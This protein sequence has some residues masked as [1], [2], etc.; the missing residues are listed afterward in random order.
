M[1]ILKL[2]TSLLY[3]IVDSGFAENLQS[4]MKQ[5]KRAG[6]AFELGSLSAPVLD[7]HSS[8]NNGESDT[9]GTGIPIDSLPLHTFSYSSFRSASRNPELCQRAIGIFLSV[10]LPVSILC[11]VLF[12]MTHHY[13]DI[14]SVFRRNHN[15]RW[16]NS[17]V[18]DI[19]LTNKYRCSICGISQKPISEAI[20]QLEL[21]VP[22]TRSSALS[23]LVQAYFNALEVP[24]SAHKKATAKGDQ[25]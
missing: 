12:Q 1:N 2:S 13:T 8:G 19:G 14:M 17:D 3:C 16:I 25:V 7:G 9:I 23:E 11:L 21:M 24:H 4:I 18:F 10:M 15:L 6:T 22:F 20:T 5:W